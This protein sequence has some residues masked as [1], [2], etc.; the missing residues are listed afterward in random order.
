MVETDDLT[1][2]MSGAQYGA[3]GFNLHVGQNCLFQRVVGLPQAR[4]A[5]HLGISVGQVS[6]LVVH[7]AGHITL[8]PAEGKNT[9]HQIPEAEVHL[10][11][12]Q[13]MTVFIQEI[14]LNRHGLL[15]LFIPETGRRQ[16]G[17]QVALGWQRLG[18]A[19]E[20]YLLGLPI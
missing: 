6:A 1:R 3:G 14:T 10:Q 2:R 5:F 16:R 15:T 13:S 12:P 19:G 8:S 17:Y 9:L 7:Q 20:E 4:H 11:S 18:Q